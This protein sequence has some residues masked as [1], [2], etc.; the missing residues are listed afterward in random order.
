MAQHIL[1]TLILLFSAIQVNSSGVITNGS[2]IP[3]YRVLIPTGKT[4]N[5]LHVLRPLPVSDK[6][7]DQAKY[8]FEKTF[9]SESVTLYGYL[10]TWLV[11]QGK[12]KEVEPA[13][14]LLSGREGGFPMQGFYL[15][16]GGSYDRFYS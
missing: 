1:I 7:Y 5:D 16:E 11:N 13:Y 10:Q 14:L 4:K 3:S 2:P 9:I 15:E 8:L 12:K 6:R